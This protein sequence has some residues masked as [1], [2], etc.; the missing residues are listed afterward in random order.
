MSI[1]TCADIVLA[2]LGLTETHIAS[3]DTV[4]VRYVDKSLFLDVESAALARLLD[5][6]ADRAP[7]FMGS[8]DFSAK[9]QI[10]TLVHR[11]TL[12]VLE[13]YPVTAPQR[14][15]TWLS[16]LDGARP[17]NDVERERLS[18][19]FRRER[20][21]RMALLEH[22]L[23]TPC[24]NSTSMAARR[25][26]QTHLGLYPTYEDLGL[27]LR[28]IRARVGDGPIDADMWRDLLWLGRSDEGLIRVVH[29]AAIG[30][31]G[32]DPDLLD[33]LEQMTRIIEPEWNLEQE[34]LDAEDAAR[35]HEMLLAHR[36]HHIEHVHEVATGSI[37]ALAGAAEVYLGRDSDFDRSAPPI[38]RMQEL[39]GDP[40]TDSSAR[41][42][43]RGS[44]SQRFA[45]RC[46]DRPSLRAA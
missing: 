34:R 15:W 17:N 38:V 6:I 13:A 27:L 45:H 43:R 35:R 28:A 1:E 2:H 12:T 9:R 8:A 29:D 36:E 40:L 24:A 11:L 7:P 10:T 30:S 33:I 32:G 19:L 39:L 18:E 23:L 44:R 31:A 14:V 4:V 42:I 21:L 5:M 46:A 37:N 22:V 16:W 25:L 20:T 41:W 3:P 26:H